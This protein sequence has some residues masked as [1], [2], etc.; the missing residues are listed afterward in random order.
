MIR[1]A[2]KKQFNR[3]AADLKTE[4]Y[5]TIGCLDELFRKAGFDVS[6]TKK[7][8]FVYLAEAIKRRV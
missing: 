4:F 8:R 6:F 3:L 7:N 2:E 5:T 1:E